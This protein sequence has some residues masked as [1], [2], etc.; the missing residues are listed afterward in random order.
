MNGHGNVH[1]AS[2]FL[3][4]NQLINPAQSVHWNHDIQSI[5]EIQP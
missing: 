1:D 3:H 2:M 4:Y 5:Q